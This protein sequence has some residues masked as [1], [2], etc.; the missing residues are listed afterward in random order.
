M[1]GVTIYV[2]TF[3]YNSPTPIFC[4]NTKIITAFIEKIKS[5]IVDFRIKINNFPKAILSIW[6]EK[7]SI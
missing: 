3:V 7:E 2:N 4:K 1:I 5:E 6:R